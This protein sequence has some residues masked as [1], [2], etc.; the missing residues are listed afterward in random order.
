MSKKI[1]L[2]VL[3]IVVAIGLVGV[4]T[5]ALYH[6]EAPAAFN[7]EAAEL[8]LDRVSIIDYE[9]VGTVA[10]GWHTFTGIGDLNPDASPWV[11]I[12]KNAGNMP[13]KVS[14]NIA[15][16]DD[17][18]AGL[19]P[20]EEAM[21]DTDATGE[22]GANTMVTVYKDGTSFGPAPG[23]VVWGPGSFASLKAACPIALGT[24][25]AGEQHAYAMKIWIP[26]TVGNDIQSD[27]LSFKAVYTLDQ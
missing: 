14:M 16:W 18:E 5:W 3:V 12:V 17:D 27:E 25:A 20:P 11:V 13:G 15:D 21:G 1:L 6:D 19:M 9:M 23:T 4:G 10:P 8:Y 26:T 2:S 24:Y 22:L 7:G